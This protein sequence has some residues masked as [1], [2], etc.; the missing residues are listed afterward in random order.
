MF[1][2][3][4]LK[5]FALS[6]FL[7][8]RN[9]K[10]LHLFLKDGVINAPILALIRFDGW[11][12]GVPDHFFFFF[13]YLVFV[14]SENLLLFT[15]FFFNA[16]SVLIL[17]LIFFF[18]ISCDHK[19]LEV[20]VGELFGSELCPGLFASELSGYP[21]IKFFWWVI[22]H[23]LLL[24]LVEDHHENVLVT[25]DTQFNNFLDKPSFPFAKC[26]VSLVLVQDLFEATP[27]SWFALCAL[28]NLL[29][30]FIHK[31]RFIFNFKQSD[32]CI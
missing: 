26:Y 2:L 3:S 23:K 15:I 19:S 27:S 12:E 20:F 4:F 16:Q 1:L 8:F 18:V 22:F 32:R 10:F 24:L 13:L 29:R 14:N 30:F 25:Q 9:D 21:Q 7:I 5:L 31:D 11:I 28:S 17:G 6:F